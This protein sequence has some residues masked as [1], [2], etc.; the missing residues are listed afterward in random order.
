VAGESL[1]ATTR[2]AES[3]LS[4]SEAGVMR[5]RA[6]EDTVLRRRNAGDAAVC[7]SSVHRTSRRVA[8]FVTGEARAGVHRRRAQDRAA[9]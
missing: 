7:V 5:L 3:E 9:V 4:V 2:D 1:E 8:W 6:A